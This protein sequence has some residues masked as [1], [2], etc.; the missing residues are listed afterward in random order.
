MMQKLVFAVEV[1]VRKIMDCVLYA[2][3]INSDRY[4]LQDQ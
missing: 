4:E 3:S 2:D 1:S